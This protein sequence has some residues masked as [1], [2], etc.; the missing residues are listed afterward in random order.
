MIRKK[1]LII[2][3]AS[4]ESISKISPSV[5]VISNLK[6]SRDGIKVSYYQHP[7]AFETP[8][9]CFSQHFITIHLNRASVV[10]E[11]VL[12]SRLRCDNFRDG[13]ICLTPANAPVWVR[14][15]DS[16]ELICLYLEPKILR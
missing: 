12:N 2:N 9:H 10:K 5:P 6:S 14:L 4:D 15:H 7:G 11:Q 13:D 16:S 8:E 1:P 3:A